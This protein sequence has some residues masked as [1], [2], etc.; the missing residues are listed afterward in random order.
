VNILVVQPLNL[1]RGEFDAVG[2]DGLLDS[3]DALGTGIAVRNDRVT[4]A[5]PAIPWQATRR[6]LLINS[7]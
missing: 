3:G 5:Q 4:A 7:S 6:R 2:G 1:L